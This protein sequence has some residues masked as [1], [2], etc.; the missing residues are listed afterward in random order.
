MYVRLCLYLSIY[1]CKYQLIHV[2][3]Y[4]IIIHQHV[5]ISTKYMFTVYILHINP[6]LP[7]LLYPGPLGATQ[8]RNSFPTTTTHEEKTM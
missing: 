8:K 4:V 6:Q 1:K 7:K 3:L 5:Q 2:C